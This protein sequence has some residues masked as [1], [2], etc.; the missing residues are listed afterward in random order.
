MEAAQELY[1]NG[2]LSYPRTDSTRLSDVYIDDYLARYRKSSLEIPVIGEE[3]ARSK[4]SGVRIQDAHEALHIIGYSSN[5]TDENMKTVVEI[6]KHQ[7]F[8]S[9]IY[10][11]TVLVRCSIGIG[12]DFVMEMNIKQADMLTVGNYVEGEL[13]ENRLSPSSMV[14]IMHN[15]GIGRPSTTAGVIDNLLEKKY[16]ML[17]D[18]IVSVT[19]LGKSVIEEGLS[20]CPFVFESDLTS[21]ME[22]HLDAIAAGGTPKELFKEVYELVTE[23]Q[24]SRPLDYKNHQWEP[25]EIPQNTTILLEY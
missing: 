3:Y 5:V 18:D 13:F 6:I 10:P 25:V 24:E 11:S 2:I 17:Q 4:V 12:N 8:E 20:F 14:E 15:V 16:V 23:A 9:L 1:N 22:M 19:E 21:R 7:T